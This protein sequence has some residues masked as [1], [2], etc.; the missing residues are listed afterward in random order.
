[1]PIQKTFFFMTLRQKKEKKK[2]SLTKKKN[3]T[4]LI[5][6]LWKDFNKQWEQHLITKGKSSADILI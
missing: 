6:D 1:M 2:S 5:D 3:S 4:A